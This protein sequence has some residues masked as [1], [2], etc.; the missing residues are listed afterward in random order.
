MQGTHP[1]QCLAHCVLSAAH[2]AQRHA[3]QVSGYNRWGN[4]AHAMLA[5]AS[6]GA[7]NDWHCFFASLH[8]AL[9]PDSSLQLIPLCRTDHSRQREHG[10]ADT[11]LSVVH[12]KKGCPPAAAG[13][14]PASHYPGASCSSGICCRLVTARFVS[15]WL[16]PKRCCLANSTNLSPCRRLKQ[17][18]YGCPPGG[19]HIYFMGNACYVLGAR[20]CHRQL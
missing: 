17:S 6:S 12:S 13:V 2:G 8:L 7:L 20:S 3:G 11:V 4:L 18:F 15:E 5:D 1:G 19:L 9:A 16:L 14:G 10:A